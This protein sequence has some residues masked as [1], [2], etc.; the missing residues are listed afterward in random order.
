MKERDKKK[1]LVVTSLDEFRELFERVF[2]D[3]DFNWRYY[4]NRIMGL[5]PFHKERN[6]SFNIFIAPDG[7]LAYKCFSCDEKGTIGKFIRKYLKDGIPL[8]KSLE[9]E[10]Q[11][12]QENQKKEEWKLKEIANALVDYANEAFKE[13][14][15]KTKLMFFYQE[16]QVRLKAQFNYLPPTKKTK[17]AINFFADKAGIFDVLPQNRWEEALLM[18]ADYFKVGIITYDVL[19]ALEKEYPEAFKLLN[20]KYALYERVGWF[21]LPYY[22]L[23][24]YL[25]GIKFRDFTQSSRAS[26]MLSLFRQ[27]QFFGAYGYVARVVKSDKLID[28]FTGVVE[29]ESD[30]LAYYVSSLTKGELPVLA[31]GSATNYQ[32]LLEETFPYTILT[33]FPDYDPFTFRSMGAGRKAIVDLYFKRLELY[34]KNKLTNKA[35][36]F[37]LCGESPY[38]IEREEDGIIIP[39]KDVNEAVKNGISIYDLYESRIEPLDVAVEVFRKQH[40]TFKQILYNRKKEE[41][42][43]LGLPGFA[44]LLAKASGLDEQKVPMKLKDIYYDVS[45]EPKRLLKIYPPNKISVVAAQGGVG[46][47]TYSLLTAIRAIITDHVKVVLW[48]TEHSE[49]EIKAIMDRII[50]Q[51]PYF[52]KH[53][54]LIE[55]NFFVL[56]TK[57]RPTPA[58]L[59]GVLDKKAI[60]EL[61]SLLREYDVVIIDPLLSFY[62]GD[63]NKSNLIRQYFDAINAV[64]SRLEEEGLTRYLIILAHTTKVRGDKDF[65]VFTTDY[66]VV[67]RDDRLLYTEIQFKNPGKPV[68]LS[69]IVRGSSDI[70]NAARLVIMLSLAQPPKEDKKGKKKK[71]DKDD[72][73]PQELGKAQRIAVI[74]KKNYPAGGALGQ[75][76]IIPDLYLTTERE[77][78]PSYDGDV[79][80]D[81]YTFE[82][83][84]DSSYNASYND[85][86][87][88]DDGNYDDGSDEND[89]VVDSF[90]F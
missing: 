73:L 9:R 2:P 20:S 27:P 18:I 53:R 81:L 46:K 62:G 56:D 24:Q 50:S 86:Y 68:V 4:P 89:D 7:T 31:V 49:Q 22:N 45:K 37:V 59:T 14:V 66:D 29:G 8:P 54:E 65:Q 57:S 51:N 70:K 85:E 12:E 6:A 78:N 72:S 44:N 40:E 35:K 77:I 41:F 75:G 60:D 15:T 11:K 58:M 33:I 19:E 21:V 67:S 43:K 5:C 42:E 36:I 71:D 90:D 28:V 84:G 30:A 10:Y 69:D 88:N 34:K 83:S 26:R 32:Y 61:E 87:G 63:E 25:C 23:T 17:V 1:S 74:V 39:V 3:H 48:T 82:G 55:E 16:E 47:T 52:E 13:A 64:L 38:G 80:E 76:E 79:D